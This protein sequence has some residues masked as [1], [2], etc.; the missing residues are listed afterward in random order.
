[1]EK[2]AEAWV[3]WNCFTLSGRPQNPERN[4][5]QWR[6]ERLLESGRKVKVTNS[7]PTRA[8]VDGEHTGYVT[9][10]YAG[11]SVRS[12]SPRYQSWKI[13]VPTWTDYEVYFARIMA[14]KWLK[15]YLPVELCEMVMERL[16][17]FAMHRV[18]YYRFGPRKLQE[19][20]WPMVVDLT[21]EEE[22]TV[23]SPHIPDAMCE[24]MERRNTGREGECECCGRSVYDDGYKGRK[25]KVVKESVVFEVPQKKMRV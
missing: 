22:A 13:Y 9:T 8:L 15:R 20:R 25:V 2:E 3:D 1:M 10:Y 12:T 14:W 16:P 5:G 21:G 11:I 24:L 18:L 7:H 19:G 17:S 23:H 4:E 6:E